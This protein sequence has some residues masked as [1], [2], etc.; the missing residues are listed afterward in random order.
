MFERVVAYGD[1]WTAGNVTD[2]MLDSPTQRVW[3]KETI[4]ERYFLLVEP[5]PNI[6][7][8]NLKMGYKNY[9]SGGFS[10]R[11][12][13]SNVY[14]SVV[15]NKIDHKKDLIIVILSTWHR[16]A[17]WYSE[18][19]SIPEKALIGVNPI[20]NV[21]FKNSSALFRAYSATHQYQWNDIPWEKKQKLAY[22]T[23]YDFF[24]LVN[25]L[26]NYNFNYY[27]GYGFTYIEDFEP[28]LDKSYI[29]IIKKNKKLLKPFIDFAPT[30][31]TN[32]YL[33]HPNEEEHR[34]FSD[35]LTKKIKRDYLL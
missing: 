21:Y 31:I 18:A 12:I 5:W 22:Q 32:Q 15:F 17:I 3:F 13:V 35:Y 2:R 7:A 9:A 4:Q 20:D 23:F 16:E 34:R 6:V 1:S 29:D 8:Y 24:S 28:Y 11:T 10:N 14:D 33:L 26:E 25:L 30:A 27:I 19:D